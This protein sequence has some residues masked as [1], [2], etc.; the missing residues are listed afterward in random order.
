MVAKSG[1]YGCGKEAKLD[2]TLT[3][4]TGITLTGAKIQLIVPSNI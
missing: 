2:V 3:N 4:C 1:I